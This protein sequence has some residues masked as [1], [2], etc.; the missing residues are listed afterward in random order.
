MEDS[1]TLSSPSPVVDRYHS[2]VEQ[3][4]EESSA[5]VYC[6]WGGRVFFDNF[7]GLPPRRPSSLGASVVSRGFPP[8]LFRRTHD[9]LLCTRFSSSE[10]V[11]ACRL[12][13]TL[14]PLT[15]GDT[16][17]IRCGCSVRLNPC[18]N[19]SSIASRSRST[20]GVFVVVMPGGDAGTPAHNIAQLSRRGVRHDQRSTRVTRSVL[21]LSQSALYRLVHPGNSDSGTPRIDF[22]I[23]SRRLQGGYKLVHFPCTGVNQGQNSCAY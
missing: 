9:E 1:P 20:T 12:V 22:G 8:E 7:H 23:H 19:F 6:R 14:L 15:Q 18:G 17:F 11:C 5:V 10:L 16:L 4:P 21:D 2:G 3:L 13:I